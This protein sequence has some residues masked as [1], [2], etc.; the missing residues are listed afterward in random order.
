M[1]SLATKIENELRRLVT[2]A[3]YLAWLLLDPSK[4][5]L[6]D[7]R[8]IKKIL[9]IHLGAMGEILVSTPLLPALKKELNAEIKYMVSP[10]KEDILK[11]NPYVSEVLTYKKS[12]REN[13]NM[14]KKEKFN[15]AVILWPCAL[16]ITF[17]CLLAGIKYRIGGFKNIRDGINFFFTRRMLD[18]RK[19]HAI[20]CNL[21]VIRTIGID[22]KN[23]K[24]EFYISRRDSE[25]AKQKLSKL[26]AKDFIVIHPGFSFASTTKYPSRWWPAERYAEVADYLSK[27][28]NLK[29]LL[30]GSKNEMKF[31]EDI[32]RISKN[33]K[34]II[35]T[36]DM[37]ATGE[38]AYVLSKSKIVIAP[39]TGTIHLT[40]AFNSPIVE[41]IGKENPDEWQPWTSEENY[42]II[43]HPEVCT[44]CD[45][46]F[47]RKKTQECMLSITPHEV[48]KA[49]ESFLR[50]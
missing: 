36:N 4:F 11:N 2:M 9:V 19:K 6:I 50:K 46:N 22:N 18:L 49:A 37:F 38:F 28:C 10:G 29:V 42:K 33:K 13:L 20:Q 3:D 15:L 39:G 8:K 41:L 14:L 1:K 45:K 48:I 16:K 12:F 21:D 23:P 24:I 34:N 47:C 43:Y 25:N 7:K 35:I 30:T 32:K 17:M 40:T 27:K 44:E 5:T 26:K 31:S